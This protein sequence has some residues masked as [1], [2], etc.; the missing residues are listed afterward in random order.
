MKQFAVR[1][2]FASAVILLPLFAGT[3]HACTCGPL[4]TP[5]EAFKE[6]RVVFAGKVVSSNVPAYD[7]LR[8][9]D[10]T[11]VESVFR[12]AVTESFKGVRTA[13]IEITAGNTGT[14]C[15]GGLTVGNTY[16]VYG[17]DFPSSALTSGALPYAGTCTRTN[18]L[19]WA[20]D[21]VHYLRSMLRGA[22]EPRVY[23]SLTRMDNDP[24]KPKSGV[25]VPIEGV[26]IIVEGGKRRFEAVTDKRG[27]FKLDKVPDGK[28]KARPMLPDKYMSYWPGEEEFVLGTT[29]EPMDLSTRRGATAYAQFRIGWNNELSGRVL[30]AEGNPIRRAKAALYL[31]RQPH[32][33][34]LL[35]EE[36]SHDL[37][38]GQ[39]R[40]HGLL[41]GRYLPAVTV[42]APFRTGGQQLRFYYPGA[43]NSSQAAGI[44]VTESGSL[45]AKDIRLPAGYSVRHIEG[46]LVWPDGRPVAKNGW[47][48]LA[49]KESL[50]D[51]DKRYDFAPADEQGRFSVQGFVGAEYWVHVTVGTSGMKLNS[52][53][54]L[55][56][57]GVRDLRAQP[58]KVTI[59]KVNAP[60]RITVPLPA[61]VS[62]GGRP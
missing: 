39:Y 49:A 41:P 61:G 9:G 38:E 18:G 17:Y 56:G 30:D 26:K 40:F 47:V 37:A 48:S 6:A 8:A 23:G 25:A 57:S 31:L 4:P 12:F 42:E 46:V 28:Y 36:G 54:D 51:E 32:G 45:S 62:L 20:Q 35:T 59:G 3:A 33:S 5:Y 24:D 15:Y 13:E 29:D 19:T 53:Q 55:W 7:Q 21:D 2:I 16:L 60:L 22:P 50:G 27:L 10:Y 58:V 14:S 34:P 44:E 43:A 11:A 52:G 1:I